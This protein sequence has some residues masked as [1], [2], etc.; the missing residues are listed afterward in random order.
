MQ[1]KKR[2]WKRD[3]KS[4]GL[5]LT[6]RLVAWPGH[7]SGGISWQ[8][9]LWHG[10]ATSQGVSAD[11]LP[12][13]MARPPVRRH[14]LTGRLVAWPGHQ[15][16]GISWQA[17]LS[18]GQAT[19]QVP[20]ADRPPCGMA[21]PPVRGKCKG[22]EPRDPNRQALYTFYFCVLPTYKAICFVLLHVTSYI[23]G[24][25]ESLWL[26]LSKVFEKK[27]KKIP[28]KL[29]C[30][31]PLN[32]AVFLWHKSVNSLWRAGMVSGYRKWLGGRGSSP[33]VRDDVHR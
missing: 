26:S 12:C 30:C 3:T 8:V 9:A 4:R 15:S 11:K 23:S 31:L 33:T 32:A 1:S 28:E 16:G 29:G 2:P 20:S 10:Q 19:S 5:Q 14:Q 24:H 17:A 22:L 7:Q 13:G 27:T 6:S 21:R 18:H 25:G